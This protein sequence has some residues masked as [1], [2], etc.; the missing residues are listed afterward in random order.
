VGLATVA[1]GQGHLF[2]LSGEPG[3]AKIRLADEFGR[4]AVAQGALV[5]RGRC[6]EG[7]D[8]PAYWPW[9]QVVRAAWPTAM[10]NT[11]RRFSARRQHRR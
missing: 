10:P 5:T 8:A 6:W 11:E 4:L 2:L 1:V 3:T 7:G 9:I